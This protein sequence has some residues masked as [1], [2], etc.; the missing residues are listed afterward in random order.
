MWLPQ[1]HL[2]SAVTKLFFEGDCCTSPAVPCSL[3]LSLH[4]LIPDSHLYFCSKWQTSDKGLWNYRSI[5]RMSQCHMKNKTHLQ[6]MISRR[7]RPDT[8][9]TQSP[10]S[11]RINEESAKEEQGWPERSSPGN[12]PTLSL[13]VTILYAASFSCSYCFYSYSEKTHKWKDHY[14]KMSLYIIKEKIKWLTII[15]NAAALKSLPSS[16]L[17]TS[18]HSGKYNEGLEQPELLNL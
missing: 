7:A 9:T 4:C 3:A 17:N 10:P 6:G 18:N 15:F 5:R 1:S 11:C 14:S 8:E 13:E 16:P 12:K 2:V